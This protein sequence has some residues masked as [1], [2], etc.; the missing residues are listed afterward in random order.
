MAIQ[1]DFQNMPERKMGGNG[2]GPNYLKFEAGKTYRIRPV[3]GAV[4]FFKIFVR[5]KKGEFRSIVVDADEKESVCQMISKE[6]GQ[7]V[8]A[9]PRYAMHVIHRDDGQIK[10]LEAGPSIFENFGTWA[11]ANDDHPG[12]K[13]GGD[14]VIEVTGE[15]LQRRYKMSFLK[16]ALVTAEEKALL[17]E[18]KEQYSL[19]ALYSSCPTDEVMDRITGETSKKG[20][21]DNA[22]A[23][24]STDIDIDV[25]GDDVDF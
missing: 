11:K 10:I 24:S 21:D 16:Q 5:N 1:V 20:P 12:S 3:G 14:W 9:D 22:S 25:D 7:D 18:K 4:E 17:D 23:D 6:L 15:K 13:T 8:K 2:Q 19:K